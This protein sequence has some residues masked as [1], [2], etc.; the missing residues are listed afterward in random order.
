MSAAFKMLNP[1]QKSNIHSTGLPDKAAT[2]NTVQDSFTSASKL[3]LL[4]QH[5]M[6]L[7]SARNGERLLLQTH[8]CDKDGD[9]LVAIQELSALIML[10]RRHWCGVRIGFKP[11]SF[12]KNPMIPQPE[13]CPND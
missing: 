6:R 11:W 12:L 8:R 9:I 10:K 2:K 5:R 3:S 7:R 1:Q 13:T 4:F